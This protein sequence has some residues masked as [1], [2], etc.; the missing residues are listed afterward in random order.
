METIQVC[1]EFC[2]IPHSM[3]RTFIVERVLCSADL[4]PRALCVRK[5]QDRRSFFASLGVYCFYTLDAA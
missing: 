2:L 3:Q 5:E 1:P 4:H